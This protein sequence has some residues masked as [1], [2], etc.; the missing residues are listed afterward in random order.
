MSRHIS[1]TVKQPFV[2]SGFPHII[3]EDLQTMTGFWTSGV[4]ASF[5]SVRTFGNADGAVLVLD[6]LQINLRVPKETEK[7]IA[8]NNTS[9]GRELPP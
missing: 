9:L 2:S 5:K 6:G 3:C 1:E 8:T 4:G 7:E